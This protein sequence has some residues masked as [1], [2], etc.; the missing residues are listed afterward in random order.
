MAELELTF[1]IHPFIEDAV[2]IAKKISDGKMVLTTSIESIDNLDE[3]VGYLHN[4]WNK[5]LI[6]DTVV[7]NVSVTLGV[8]FGEMIINEKS[9]HWTIN[10]EEL[11]VVE[12]EDGNQLSPISKLYK[13]IIDEDDCEGTA[14]GFYEGFK[15]LEYYDSLGDDEKENLPHILNERD[16]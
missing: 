13:I 7:W 8:L 15:A 5:N 4:L 14:R 1:S 6:D 11:P 3:I 12:T 9:F 16:G 10:K 2:D